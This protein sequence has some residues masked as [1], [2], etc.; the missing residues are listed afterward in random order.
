MRLES[1]EKGRGALLL[2]PTAVVPDD[3]GRCSRFLVYHGR[4]KLKVRGLRAPGFCSGG[5]ERVLSDACEAWIVC[6]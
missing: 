1:Q 3:G 5:R 2:N 6:A 4:W